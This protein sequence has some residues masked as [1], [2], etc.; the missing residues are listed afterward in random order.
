MRSLAMVEI[1][2]IL[3]ERI[4]LSEESDEVYLNILDGDKTINSWNTLLCEYK[5]T[6]DFVLSRKPRG[7]KPYN[8]SKLAQFDLK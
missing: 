5:P 4:E 6:L 7:L 2:L 1:A 8:V 3:T